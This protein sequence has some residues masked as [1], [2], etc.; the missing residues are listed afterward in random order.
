MSRTDLARARQLL[1]LRNLALDTA[2]RALAAAN[3]GMAVADTAVAAA[4]GD[5][6][7][8]TLR[9]A[10]ARAGLVEN[11]ADTANGLA[12]VALAAD[13]QVAAVEAAD[14]AEQQR[15]IAEDAV[16]AARHAVRRARART[17]AMQG[18]ADRAGRMLARAAEERAAAESDE[19]AAAMRS[20]A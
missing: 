13:R 18:Y 4:L 5:R 16:I 1:R 3:A 15:R 7:A 20:A 8:A 10:A 19:G 17:D 14:A 6:E 12:R 9:H 11:P 2:L